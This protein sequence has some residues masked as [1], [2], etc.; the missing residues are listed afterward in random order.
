VKALRFLGA[1][2]VAGGVAACGDGTGPRDLT[3]LEANLALVAVE[4]AAQD[5]EL[6]RGPGG[7]WGLGL[8]AMPGRF[9]CNTVEL[10][11]WTI[12]RT[13]AFYDADGNEQEAYD[14]ETTASATLH[15]EVSGGMERDQMSATM[16]R[17]RDLT[18]AGLAGAETAITWNGTG[19]TEMSRVRTAW[20]GEQVEMALSAEESITDVVIPVPRTETGWPL[21]GTIT[22]HVVVTFTGG[23][24]DG[25]TRERDVTITFD[26]TQ[27][28]TVTVNGET[29]TVDL[30]LRRHRE[31]MR[32][33][34]GM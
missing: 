15:I 25:T 13:C 34:R 8:P 23:R 1:A 5:V 31:G 26:G 18:V 17:V 11:N 10:V 14:P 32:R 9:E 4:Q 2:V 19:T 27:F 21:G 24:R 7:P 16:E 29:F 6:M 12:T 28:A 22:Q 20:S 33:H 3:S 30:A